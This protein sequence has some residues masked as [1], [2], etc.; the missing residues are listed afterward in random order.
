MGRVPFWSRETPAD[1]MAASP[2]GIERPT[3][4]PQFLVSLMSLKAVANAVTL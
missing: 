4:M 1:A 3:M 2:S